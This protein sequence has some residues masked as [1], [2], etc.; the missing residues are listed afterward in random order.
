MTRPKSNHNGDGRGKVVFPEILPTAADSVAS[1]DNAGV[2][3]K[4]VFKRSTAYRGRAYRLELGYVLP[5]P[6]NNF[7]KPFGVSW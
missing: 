7:Y 2:T 3:A 6:Q 4:V 5:G 1:E